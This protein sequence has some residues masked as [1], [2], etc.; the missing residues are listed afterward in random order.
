MNC[1]TKGY[2]LEDTGLFG[3]I[4]GDSDHHPHTQDLL[5]TKLG[6][7]SSEL[8][9]DKTQSWVLSLAHL[10]Q[11]KQESGRVSLAKNLPPLISNQIPGP[12]PLAPWPVF[13]QNPA[14][15]V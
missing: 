10:I 8:H 14:E 4:Q 13:S 6:S 12:P 7:S 3:V 9:C 2:A 1:P 15:S 11:L 5:L